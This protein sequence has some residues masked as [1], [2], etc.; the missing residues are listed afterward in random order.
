MKIVSAWSFDC[1]VF[2]T[3]EQER[4]QVLYKGELVGEYF[5]ILSFNTN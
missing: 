5:R 2:P 3:T 1:A 4:Y